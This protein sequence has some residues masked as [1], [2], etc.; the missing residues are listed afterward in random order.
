VLKAYHHPV[1]L[2]CNLGTLTSWNR[3]GHSRPVTGLLYLYLYLYLYHLLFFYIQRQDRHVRINIT[4]RRV[5]VTTVTVE[6]QRVVLKTIKITNVKHNSFIKSG[7]YM[8]RPQTVIIRPYNNLSQLVLY[9][10]WDPIMSRQNTQN[11]HPIGQSS[12][13]EV[14]LLVV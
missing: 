11:R 13:L 7:G 4:F 3:L 10:Y 2:S 6:K 14:L 1:P 12:T 8:F 5:G 9:T